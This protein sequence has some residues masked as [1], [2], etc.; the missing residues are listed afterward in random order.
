MLSLIHTA[1]SK[2]LD[3]QHPVLLN[4][5]NLLMIQVFMMPYFILIPILVFH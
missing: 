2:L 5:I 1:H 4:P 3:L